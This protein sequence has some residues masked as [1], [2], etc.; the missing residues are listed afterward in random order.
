[1][2]LW[3]QNMD[4]NCRYFYTMENIWQMSELLKYAKS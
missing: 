2:N 3:K 1:M 4:E